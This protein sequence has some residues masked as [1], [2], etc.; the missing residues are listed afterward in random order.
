MGAAGVKT[1]PVISRKDVH[2]LEGIV[3]IEDVLKVYGL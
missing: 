1:L 3:T 2:K